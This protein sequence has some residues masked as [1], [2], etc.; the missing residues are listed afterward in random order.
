MDV[1]IK[2]ANNEEKKSLLSTNQVS[3]SYGSFLQAQDFHSGIISK[4][5]GRFWYLSRK[6]WGLSGKIDRLKDNVDS[7]LIES[8][9]KF[10]FTGI[11]NLSAPPN[12]NI[13]GEGQGQIYF[14]NTSKDVVSCFNYTN[15]KKD[16]ITLK[17]PN[18]SI[19]INKGLQKLYVKEEPVSREQK[20]F[21]NY[22]NQDD[23]VKRLSAFKTGLNHSVYIH[24][25]ILY[26]FNNTNGFKQENCW[27]VTHPLNAS[28]DKFSISLS[29]N[30]E[31]II[32]RYNKV[33]KPNKKA[34]RVYCLIPIKQSKYYEYISLKFPLEKVL[35]NA[36]EINQEK[37]ILHSQTS[38]NREKAVALSPYRDAL[39]SMNVELTEYSIIKGMLDENQFG[40]PIFTTSVLGKNISD[41][42][43]IRDSS[44]F[45]ISLNMRYIF[46]RE[47]CGK[48][49]N[50]YD[51]KGEN[52]KMPESIPDTI[53]MPLNVMGI[54][55]NLFIVTEKLNVYSLKKDSVWTLKPIGRFGTNSNVSAMRLTGTPAINDSGWIAMNIRA[56]LN[57][58]G[59]YDAYIGLLNVANDSLYVLQNINS[60]EAKYVYKYSKKGGDARA[61]ILRQTQFGQP[62]ILH[63]FFNK[64]NLFVRDIS[65][66]RNWVFNN[67][68][69]NLDSVFD[70]NQNK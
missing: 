2:F 68:I 60:M 28:L 9:N 23:A 59:A 25:S 58:Y 12:Y 10:P 40:E 43:I 27:K 19:D 67:R 48:K 62:Q 49:W 64:K 11:T 36:T 55:K 16:T 18:R 57:P 29:L 61:V 38:I 31:F 34:Y 7:I 66:I 21:E 37:I 33:G 47:S 44:C 20:Y 4:I 42:E 15:S 50:I 41:D 35:L 53:G 13:L 17:L 70:L 51:L 32:L 6:I 63:W 1:I 54:A 52:L 30:D 3:G 24:D 5:S 26:L 65:E 39:Y 56:E 69:N 46:Y 14:V 8:F 22:I 45:V